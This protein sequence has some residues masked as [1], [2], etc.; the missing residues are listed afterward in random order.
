MKD[1]YVVDIIPT[2]VVEYKTWYEVKAERDIQSNKA[3]YVT[4]NNKV[5]I[6]KG[7]YNAMTLNIGLRAETFVFTHGNLHWYMKQLND[8]VKWLEDRSLEKEGEVNNRLKTFNNLPWYK[9]MFFKFEL[10]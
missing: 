9:K 8:K 5:A 3:F 1:I 4:E 10:I 6:G 7:M 2:K